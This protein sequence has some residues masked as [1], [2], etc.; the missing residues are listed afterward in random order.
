MVRSSFAEASLPPLFIGEVARWIRA[1]PGAAGT[2]GFPSFLRK[3]GMLPPALRATPLIN[4]GG[5][6]QTFRHRKNAPCVLH[7]AF[8][9]FNQRTYSMTTRRFG[10][11]P[12]EWVV[13]L[14]MSCREAWITWRS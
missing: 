3:E 14:S 4:V 10:S 13:M 5:K 7:G 2:E 12:V 1:K 11:V 6:S 8:L 9:H